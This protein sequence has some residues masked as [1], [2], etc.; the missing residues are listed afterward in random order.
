MSYGSESTECTKTDGSDEEDEM[1]S[2]L[3]DFDVSSAVPV[4]SVSGTEA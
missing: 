4:G 3:V 2:T 1:D